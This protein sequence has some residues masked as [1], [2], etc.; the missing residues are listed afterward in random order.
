MDASKELAKVVRSSPKFFRE[1]NMMHN[2]VESIIELMWFSNVSQKDVVYGEE[3]TTSS[4]SLLYLFLFR[5]LFAQCERH[6][7]GEIK[8][9]GHC[10]LPRH[11]ELC[12]S[13]CPYLRS[14]S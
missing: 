10:S 13:Y 3:R 9:E 2:L 5:V 8:K 4:I 12:L 6:L 11:G 14:E 1:G 7:R